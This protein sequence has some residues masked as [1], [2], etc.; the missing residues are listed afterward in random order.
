MVPHSFAPIIRAKER[1]CKQLFAQQL[2]QPLLLR[3]FLGG[4]ALLQV[5]PVLILPVELLLPLF[6]LLAPA[7]G[8]QMS[9]KLGVGQ[10]GGGISAVQDGVHIIRVVFDLL[11]IKLSGFHSIAA[12]GAHQNA[13]SDD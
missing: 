3:Q 5:H 2:F 12:Q 10:G 13:G 6:Q 9:Q 1:E 7:L 8:Q 11:G 4:V